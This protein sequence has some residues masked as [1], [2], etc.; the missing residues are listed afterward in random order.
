MTWMLA[1]IVCGYVA[2]VVMGLCWF[3]TLCRKVQGMKQAASKAPEKVSTES[4]NGNHK[5]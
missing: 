3:L 2:D 1:S 4:S 5:N